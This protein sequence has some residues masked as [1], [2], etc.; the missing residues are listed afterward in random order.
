[1]ELGAN[2]AQCPIR[3]LYFGVHLTPTDLRYLREMQL[4]VNKGWTEL[5]RTDFKADASENMQCSMQT[6][7]LEP[8]SCSGLCRECSRTEKTSLVW[9]SS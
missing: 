9:L 3:S 7:T 2:S 5:Y 6:Q 8:K 4:K 1:M